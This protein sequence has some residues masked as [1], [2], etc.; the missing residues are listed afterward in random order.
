M[1][2]PLG[3][4]LSIPM[5]LFAHAVLVG[6]DPD[7]EWARRLLAGA[8]AVLV[9]AWPTPDDSGTFFK[10][11]YTHFHAAA[12]N[13]AQRAAAALQQTQSEMKAGSGYRSDPAFWSAYSLISKE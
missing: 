4:V 10:S 1:L 11:F 8:S 13:V 6:Q 12:G 3:A 9:T 5:T 7:R 2:G